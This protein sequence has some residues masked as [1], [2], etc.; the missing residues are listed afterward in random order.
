MAPCGPGGPSAAGSWCRPL[1]ILIVTHRYPPDGNAGV[2][3]Y[4]ATLAKGFRARGREVTVLTAVKDVARRDGS[5]ARREH[6]G[7]PVIEVT[8]NLYGT[9]FEETYSNPSMDA[10]VGEQLDALQPDIVHVHHML[11]LSVGILGECRRRGIPVLLTLHDFWLGCA[12]FGQLL[13]ADGTRCETVDPERCGTCLPT[14]RWA[15]PAGARRVGKGLA[16]IKSLT[17]LDFSG[18]LTRVHRRRTPPGMPA[19]WAPPSRAAAGEYERLAEERVAAIAGAVR[20]SASRILLPSK[21]QKPWLENLGVPPELMHVEPTGIDWQRA[22]ECPRVDRVAGEPLRV[23]FLGTL[24]PHKGAHVL[25]DA[26]ARMDDEL[27]RRA[28]LSI[29]GPG[30]NRPVYVEELRA[31][32]AAL[33]VQL[34]GRLDRA[35]VGK[36]LSATDVLVIPSLWLEVRPLVMMEAHAAGARVVASDLGG[37]AEVLSDGVP[38]RAFLAGD[39]ADLARALEAEVLAGESTVRLQA[40]APLGPTASF[41]SWDGLTDAFLRHSQD[42][43]G[44]MD[45]AGPAV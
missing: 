28:Q 41:P 25:L 31:S 35:A 19:D 8:N 17:G 11:Y 37:M 36:L 20:G 34:G 12:R 9:R 1:R 4:A 22:T 33:G 43:L 44:D 3:T 39:A 16:A 18:A 7:V 13:H 24:V 29:F 40:E 15:Q 27:R 5:V 21:F 23:T 26:W 38:G 2:E 14:L 45:S 6:E 32:A 10:L 30:D 42:L